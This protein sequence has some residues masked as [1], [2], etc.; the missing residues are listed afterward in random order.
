M[1]CLIFPILILIIDFKLSTKLSQWVENGF[2]TEDQKIKI[3]NF[4][5]SQSTTN[6]ILFGVS[7]FGVS[8]VILGL[9]Y[10]VF[11]HWKDIPKSIKICVAFIFLLFSLFMA[12]DFSYKKNAILYEIFLFLSF[13]L[14]GGNLALI[15]SRKNERFFFLIWGFFGSPL[16]FFSGHFLV[17]F[18]NFFCVFIGLYSLFDHYW[19]EKMFKNHQASSSLAFTFICLSILFLLNVFT[20]FPWIFAFELWV[21]IFFFLIQFVYVDYKALGGIISSICF[22]FILFTAGFTQNIVLF[23]ITLILL[24][25]RLFMLLEFNYSNKMSAATNFILIG[26]SVLFLTYLWVKFHDL[27]PKLWKS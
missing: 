17:P 2:I 20:Q 4:E 27:I 8:L 11:A 6:P 24:V 22:I 18:L 14:I 16:S 21:Y 5:E 1:S 3:L 12:N 10:L 23:N 15:S 9:A 26:V 19:L 25:V 7:I 13:A